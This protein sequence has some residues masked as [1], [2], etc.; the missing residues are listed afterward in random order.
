MECRPHASPQFD[1]SR[2]ASPKTPGR[3][4]SVLEAKRCSPFPLRHYKRSAENDSLVP[5]VVSRVDHTDHPHG[6]H[7]ASKGTRCDHRPSNHR[8]S[9]WPRDERDPPI[10][11]FF[12]KTE[13][14]LTSN[15][16]QLVG[17]KRELSHDWT[18]Q[19][20]TLEE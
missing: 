9:D 14:D 18:G 13:N 15:S 5:P 17:S 2:Y 7:R 16:Q 19:S 11:R 12:P 4:S 8:P 3:T 1:R 10:G 20:Y 6:E